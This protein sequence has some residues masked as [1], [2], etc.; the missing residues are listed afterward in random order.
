VSKSSNKAR[1]V[2]VAVIWLVVVGICAAVYKLWIAPGKEAEVVT[3]TSSDR[4]H[5]HQLRLA[6][7]S[8]SGY[9]LLRSRAFHDDLAAHGIGLD[10][11]DDGADYGRRIESLR[12]GDVQL[13]VF[14]VDALVKASATL[15][16][17]PG[18]IVMVVDE[19]TGADAMVAYKQAVP[20]IDAL[21][22]DE[23]RLV[24]TRDSPSETLARVVMARFNLPK[25]AADPWID[26][27]GAEDVYE[28][29]K[30]ADPAAPRAYVLWEPYV[31]KALE[32][33][34][35]HVLID[36]SKFRGYIVDV[37]V[38]Q[39]K[40]LAEDER[41]PRLLKKVIE[42][43]LRANFDYQRRAG[44]LA[45]LVQEDA[46][47]QLDERLSDAQSARLV[48]SIWWKNTQENYGH[49]GIL[50]GGSSGGLQ[51]LDE[52]IRNITD[53]LVKT[54]AISND[55]TG[56]EP[57][58][59]YYDRL[60]KDL[61]AESFH[62]SVLAGEGSETIRSDNAAAA[63]SDAQWEKLSPVGELGVS[64]I[65][66]ARGASTLREQSQREL[67]ELAGTLASW[68][69]YYLLVRGHARADG[70]PEANRGLAED[71]AQAVVEFLVQQGV[72]SQRVRHQSM[73]PGGAGES[74]SVSFVVGQL[75][76]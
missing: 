35:A 19:T 44:G 38:V 52:M 74:Q 29:F 37:L 14:T 22:R 66:F 36:S 7:D 49:F 70:D 53:V 27:G 30:K 64:N 68:P 71:R 63:L 18:T 33:D 24:V 17:L 62:P 3:Q 21:N 15:G 76:Y 56:G 13:A 10:L 34:R 75:A 43:Y 20:T 39:R 42:A 73:P 5:E 67:T 51:H 31:S 1:L 48:E 47:A 54:S 25:L 6:L 23:A 40:F 46:R 32:D 28:Q 65:V 45:D 72:P 11:V 9:S 57:N 41:G 69:Q 61:H 55:P 59:L 2:V 50:A 12:N 58:K 16:E 60:L 26:A 4:R 8:F